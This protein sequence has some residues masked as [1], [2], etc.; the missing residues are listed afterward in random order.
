MQVMRAAKEAMISEFGQTP[1]QL[2]D[3]AQPHPPRQVIVPQLTAPLPGYCGV[4]SSGEE[5]S[6]SLVHILSEVAAAEPMQNVLTSPAPMLPAAA[7]PSVPG[8]QQHA[9]SANGQDAHASVQQPGSQRSMSHDGAAMPAPS[10]HAR[11]RRLSA[12]TQV[13]RVGSAVQSVLR[14]GNL[15]NGFGGGGSSAKSSGY[16]RGASTSGMGNSRAARNASA[17]SGSGGVAAPAGAQNGQQQDDAEEPPGPVFDT[18]EAMCPLIEAPGTSAGS[19]AAVVGA[20]ASNATAAPAEA[21]AGAA[22]AQ[23]AQQMQAL[24]AGSVPGEDYVNVEL[25]RSLSARQDAQ[26]AACADEASG[27]ADADA[28]SASH[29]DEE[30]RFGQDAE[31][32]HAA[33]WPSQL[34]DRIKVRF[35]VRFRNMWRDSESSPPHKSA[36]PSTMQSDQACVQAARV[37]SA[38]A[39]HAHVPWRRRDS[40]SPSRQ[41]CCVRH[42]SKLA[43]RL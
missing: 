22:A 42:L 3:E 10:S 29:R 43:A 39:A 31:I 30:E 4:P 24:R 34:H 8:V 9:K 37:R 41:L 20:S 40:G 18:P 6:Q 2:F 27:T 21:D 5:V 26:H 7:T 14:V 25:R 33:R 13:A 35:A 16:S 12:G 1:S 32:V 38:G 11:Q 19:A 23:V 15:L 28:T 36:F 17:R